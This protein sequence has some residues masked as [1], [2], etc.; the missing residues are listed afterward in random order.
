MLGN[1]WEETRGGD[2]ANSSP[3]HGIWKFVWFSMAKFRGHIVD[4][5]EVGSQRITLDSLEVGLAMRSRA[6]II[7]AGEEEGCCIGNGSVQGLC[8]YL[9][10]GLER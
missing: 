4:D 2:Y 6:V 5:G 3:R 1:A 9:G 10:R 8:D 7:F